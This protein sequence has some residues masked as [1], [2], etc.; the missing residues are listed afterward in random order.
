MK[1]IEA[2]EN[3]YKELRRLKQEYLKHEQQQ[4]ELHLVVEATNQRALSIEAQ[5]EQQ[6]AV[7]KHVQ[8]ASEDM[9]EVEH[10]HILPEDGSHHQMRELVQNQN[11]PEDSTARRTSSSYEPQH[12]I[13]AAKRNATQTLMLQQ[14][15]LEHEHSML[16]RDSSIFSIA[17]SEL[18]SS[19]QRYSSPCE[20]VG[21]FEE[22]TVGLSSDGELN[23]SYEGHRTMAADLSEH[24]ERLATSL[25]IAQ[26]MYS[27]NRSHTSIKCVETCNSGLPLR[28]P[29]YGSLH[30]KFSK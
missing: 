27:D 30:M 29:F 16:C 14:A 8:A 26:A 21:V 23:S 28:M 9:D 1:R 18:S 15:E 17:E 24:E 5:L 25:R 12:A 22:S 19:I 10:V 20:Q 13:T 4:K 2:E 11:L 3:F 6:R 7:I